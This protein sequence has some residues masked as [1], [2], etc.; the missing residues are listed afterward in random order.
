MDWWIE[1]IEGSLNLDSLTQSGSSFIDGPIT[2]Y[3]L[4]VDTFDPFELCCYTNKEGK[5]SLLSRNYRNEESINE[6]KRKLKG[7]NSIV[8]VSLI[9]EAKHGSVK[10]K[11][12]CM[13]TLFINKDEKR[14]TVIF[15]NSDVFKKLLIDVY[16]L[17][18]ILMKELGI[19]NYQLDACFNS[20]TLR[21]PF[22]YIYLKAANLYYNVE[23]HSP[24][25][26]E[27]NVVANILSTN[28]KVVKAFLS[29]YNKPTPNYK[30]LERAGRRMK[31]LDIYSE[32]EPFIKGAH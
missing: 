25:L 21:A 22:F 19:E 11:D 5:L 15:R 14:A 12:F 3:D 6:A 2:V 1:L 13:Y 18:N 28:N 7:S 32:I 10:N 17:K 20:I 24:M 4:R 26:K 27:P 30:S 8:S 16:W 29:W 9:G 23:E 31:E